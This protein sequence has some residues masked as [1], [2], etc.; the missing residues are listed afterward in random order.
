MIHSGTGTVG[1]WNLP[2]YL[3]TPSNIQLILEVFQNWIWAEVGKCGVDNIS[4]VRLVLLSLEDSYTWEIM[5]KDVWAIQQQ[6]C[7]YPL[8]SIYQC[9]QA[10]IQ[11]LVSRN[12]SEIQVS[13][14]KFCTDKIPPPISQNIIGC[15]WKKMTLSATLKKPYGWREQTAW[16]REHEVSI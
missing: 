5:W 12:I 4:W 14:L 1:V 3:V 2:S 6:A 16:Q 8:K 10:T 9:L 15:L 13:S 11:I 7:L